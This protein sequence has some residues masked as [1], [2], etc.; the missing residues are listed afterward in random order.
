MQLK[1]CTIPHFPSLSAPRKYQPFQPV[2][3]WPDLRELV[4]SASDSVETRDTDGA[5][6]EAGDGTHRARRKQADQAERNDSLI[7]HKFEAILSWAEFLN[8]NRRVDD[9]DPDNA[10]KGGG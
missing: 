2:P 3:L 9:D 5:P 7:L 4:F 6:E 1:R 10:K 8:L